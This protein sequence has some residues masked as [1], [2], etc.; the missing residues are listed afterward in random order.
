MKYSIQLLYKNLLQQIE[1][2]WML[3]DEAKIERNNR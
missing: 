1:A 3:Q 2:F